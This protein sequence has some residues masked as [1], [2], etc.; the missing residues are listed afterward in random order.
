LYAA[1]FKY[2]CFGNTC[3]FY[4]RNTTITQEMTIFLCVVSENDFCDFGVTLI[5]FDVSLNQKA[6]RCHKLTTT[7][8]TIKIKNYYSLKDV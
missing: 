2:Q 4:C 7:S 3:G 8:H 5:G 1:S 6:C